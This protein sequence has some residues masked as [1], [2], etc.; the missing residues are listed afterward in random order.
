VLAHQARANER[1]ANPLKAS[2]CQ[3]VLPYEL[4]PAQTGS[5]RINNS[6]GPKRNAVPSNLAMPR[7]IQKTRFVRLLENLPQFFLGKPV[8]VSQ[9]ILSYSFALLTP[10]G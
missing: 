4:G 2:K 7:P 6:A 10:I 8:F 1:Q 3:P 9:F 5:D